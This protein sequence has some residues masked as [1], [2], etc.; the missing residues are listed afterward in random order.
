MEYVVDSSDLS[1][2]TCTCR[3]SFDEE[4]TCPHIHAVASHLHLP[5]PD[6]IGAIYSISRFSLA[7]PSVEPKEPRA[8]ETYARKPYVD[9]QN[10]QQPAG[11]PQRNRY[12]SRGEQLMLRCGQGPAGKRP[13]FSQATRRLFPEAEQEAEQMRNGLNCALTEGNFAE[14][15]SLV[16]SEL[17]HESE[18]QEQQQQQG[19]SLLESTIAH[20]TGQEQAVAEDPFDDSEEAEVEDMRHIQRNVHVHFIEDSDDD[21]SDGHVDADLMLPLEQEESTEDL[22]DEELM[23]PDRLPSLQSTRFGRP[24]RR[25]NRRRRRNSSGSRR[26][27]SV[28]ITSANTSDSSSLSSSSVRVTDRLTVFTAHSE[29]TYASRK[30]LYNVFFITGVVLSAFL[31]PHTAKPTQRSPVAIPLTPGAVL[32]RTKPYDEARDKLI[33]MGLGLD[34]SIHGSHPPIVSSDAINE[35]LARVH[36]FT[37]LGLEAQAKLYCSD[38]GVVKYLAIMPQE[39]YQSSVQDARACPTEE[40]VISGFEALDPGIHGRLRC[41][42]WIHTH[43]KYY[44]YMSALDII[45]LYYLANRNPRSFGIVLSP[46]HKG[47]KALCVRIT[48]EGIDRY[49]SICQEYDQLRQPGRES[50]LSFAV[51]RINEDSTTKYYCQI[52]FQLVDDPCVVLDWRTEEQVRV[53]LNNFLDSDEADASWI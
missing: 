13:R 31:K 8:F 22:V 42:C 14:A 15:T 44:A 41:V 2:V 48:Q 6:S 27:S 20:G 28:S 39:N 10:V 45:Q 12:A 37:A 18:E 21:D 43:A 24:G 40:E 9:G 25:S 32:P 29:E 52:P 33:H 26:N 1:N 36:A 51:R 46:K 3:R 23:V 50:L 11:A 53:Q 30:S 19:D 17:V 35:F 4:I 34:C 38:E 49:E 47:L 16:L 5:I 7:F